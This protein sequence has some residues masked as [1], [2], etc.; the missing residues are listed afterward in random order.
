MSQHTMQGKICMITGATAGIGEATARGLAA[1]GATVI[2]V[3]RNRAKTEQVADDIRKET[4]NHHVDTALAD[5]S[6]LDQVR[7]LAKEFYARYPRL[8]VLVNNAG[9]VTR[10]REVSTDGYELMFAVNH[11]APFLLTNLLLPALKA[12]SPARIV[13]VSSFGY[14]NG[15]IHFEDLH[16][17]HHFDH[18]TAYY[19]TRL[20]TVLFTLSLAEKVTDTGVTANVLHPGIVK[21]ALSHNYMGNPVFRFFE[22]LIAVSPE[23][24]ARTS[25]YLASSP[26]VAESN[27]A[28]FENCRQKALQP[29]ALDRH[30]QEK[31]WTVS[32]KL[33]NLNQSI[34]E[35]RQPI[36]A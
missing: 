32:E 6:S 14:K 19:Q 20:A 4:G 36:S 30:L 28:Y 22:Q 5:F 10:T 13:N 33:T 11:L 23:K 15:A 24:G 3:G 18:R 31:L 17:V 35:I 34:V 21:T 16:A 27:G 7:A 12:A 1:Q 8:D 25:L 2:V 9:L 26:E 29:N